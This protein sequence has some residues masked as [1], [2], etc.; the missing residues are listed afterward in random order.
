MTDENET[1]AAVEGAASDI[2]TRAM[3]HVDNTVQAAHDRPRVVSTAEIEK[4]RINEEGRLLGRAWVL[5]AF[6][7]RLRRNR[8]ADFTV[9]IEDMRALEQ[10]ERW[11]DSVPA[12]DPS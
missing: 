12:Q 5:N 10:M 11:A 3:R 4:S 8:G 7:F 9:G 1:H 2:L 6:L